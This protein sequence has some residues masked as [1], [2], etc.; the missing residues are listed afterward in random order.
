MLH[1]ELSLLLLLLCLLGYLGCFPLLKP[2]RIALY[3]FISNLLSD[4]ALPRLVFPLFELLLVHLL[5]ESVHFPHLLDFVQ[6]HYEASLISM[7][8]LDAF[9][10]ENGEV[11]R[12]IKVLN[13]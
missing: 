5:V 4:A 12:T 9:A 8:L 11:V 3:L 13:P 6:V 2:L 7:V 10:T 1:D